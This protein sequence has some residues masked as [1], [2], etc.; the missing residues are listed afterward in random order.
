MTSQS[1]L[2]D[3]TSPVSARDA[4]ARWLRRCVAAATDATVEP[5]D[6]AEAN[7]FFVAALLLRSTHREASEQLMR[8]AERYLS[9]H[10]L[11]RLAVEDMLRRGWVPPLPRMRSMLTFQMMRHAN[12]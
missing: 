5:A 2:G 7:R 11:K 10:A 3:S 12:A 9:A 4:E 6:E 1:S 8:T